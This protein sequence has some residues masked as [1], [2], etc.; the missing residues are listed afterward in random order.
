MGLLIDFD[1][2]ADLSMPQVSEKKLTFRTVRPTDLH[3]MVPTNVLFVC[4]EL[5]DISPDRLRLVLSRT[6]FSSSLLCRH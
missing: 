1:G 3:R 2:G 4:R 6:S 5:L